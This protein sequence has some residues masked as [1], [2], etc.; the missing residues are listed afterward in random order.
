MLLQDRM[1]SEKLTDKDVEGSGFHI[2]LRI[3]PV[4]AIVQ[5]VKPQKT[6]QD[7]QIRAKF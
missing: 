1:T 4:F 5:C 7:K 3:I 6:R 2:I